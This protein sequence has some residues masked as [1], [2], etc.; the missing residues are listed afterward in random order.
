MKTAE[1]WARDVWALRY[2]EVQN[3]IATIQAESRAAGE[4]AGY[5]RG[6]AEAADVAA[7]TDIVEARDSYYAQLGDAPATRRAIV[8]A[9]RAL[10]AAGPER[11]LDRSRGIPTTTCTGC[12]LV[13]GV[14]P[15]IAEAREEGRMAGLEEAVPMILN[16]PTCGLQ[17]I[18]EGEWA[19][20][21]L[22]R[23]HLC[24]GC[25]FLWRPSDRSTVG[26]RALAKPGAKEGT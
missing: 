17:H 24:L 7:N 20:T 15:W 16:C 8:E 1:E 26:V 4:A 10:P 12:G 14:G 22:H 18:D 11:V 19:T 6:W 3:A 2:V 25:G 21:R 23:T 9:I 13:T 5:E